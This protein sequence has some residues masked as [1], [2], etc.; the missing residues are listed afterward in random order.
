MPETSPNIFRLFSYFFIEVTVINYNWSTSIYYVP[1]Q[2]T[3]QHFSI[4]RKNMH[5]W[6]SPK[7]LV[8]SKTVWVVGTI[9]NG[10]ASGG[11]R[12]LCLSGR[13]ITGSGNWPLATKN[14]AIKH[15]DRS[16]TLNKIRN[17]DSGQWSSYNTRLLLYLRLLEHIRVPSR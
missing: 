8:L 12:W 6:A 14:N 9:E 2:G 5:C 15:Y 1:R 4:E 13:D 11:C 17:N 7:L 16:L 3:T 10:W